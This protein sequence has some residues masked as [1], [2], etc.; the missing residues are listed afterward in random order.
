M[1]ALILI[2]GAVGALAIVSDPAQAQRT[3][4][5]TINR[6]EFAV[7]PFG[8][9]LVSQTFF[10]G[11]L[12]TKLGIQSAPLY[13][14]Q[15]S[16]PLAPGAS[17]IGT[18]GYASGDLKAGIPILGGISLGTSGTTLMDASVELRLE[19][20]GRSGRF[21]PV[22]ELGGGAI[23]RTVTIA[24]I[25]AKTTDFHVSGGLGADIPL[26]G[27]MAI[28]LMAKDHYGKADFGSIAGVD[29]K[30]DDLHAV[31]LTGGLRIAF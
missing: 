17:I 12:N 21:I 20:Y 23:H 4:D 22:F 27:N 16:F 8:G 14:V 6:G 25:D 11:P 3:T 26:S 2:T 29:I 15:G 1:R 13:G 5:I 31:A 24:G 19:S 9:Y 18:V 7:A 28:R 10:E 30:T